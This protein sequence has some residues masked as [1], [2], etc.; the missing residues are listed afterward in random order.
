[1]DHDS[2]DLFLGKK[3]LDRKLITPAQLREAM[4]EQARA[5]VPEGAE[6]PRLGDVFVT[7]N[8]LTR[9]QLSGLQE[10]TA[11]IVR[12]TVPPRDSIL[13]RILVDNRTITSAQLQECLRAQDEAMRSGT[14]TWSES[15]MESKPSSSAAWASAPSALGSAAGPLVGSVQP[16]ASVS[17][18]RP[19]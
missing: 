7:R 15:Q 8:L 10:E 14:T 6:P 3:A 18:I 5:S 2:E 19:G 4:T 1:M 11:R 17:G 12:G 16:T 9:D 13:G